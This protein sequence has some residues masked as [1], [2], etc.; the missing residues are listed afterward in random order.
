MFIF[1]ITG[2]G[3]FHKSFEIF[4]LCHLKFC[5]FRGMFSMYVCVISFFL[6]S[7]MFSILIVNMFKSSVIASMLYCCTNVFSRS[8]L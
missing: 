5:P 4:C 8:G 1:F 7:S 3:R 2:K 6:Q